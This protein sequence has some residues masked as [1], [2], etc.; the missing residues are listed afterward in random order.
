VAVLRVLNIILNQNEEFEK[1]GWLA[2]EKLL[3]KLRTG[4][5]LDIYTSIRCGSLPSTVH[6]TLMLTWC[7]PVGAESHYYLWHL[8]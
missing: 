7:S 8:V 5:A 6:I 1:L 3:V 4:N 2:E